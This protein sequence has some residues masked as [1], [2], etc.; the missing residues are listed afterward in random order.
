MLMNDFVSVVFILWIIF[1]NVSRNQSNS[2]L[3]LSFVHVFMQWMFV[4]GIKFVAEWGKN[5]SLFVHSLVKWIQLYCTSFLHHMN[6]CKLRLATSKQK[7]IYKSIN[8]WFIGTFLTRKWNNIFGSCHQSE[9]IKWWSI[10]FGR[11]LSY[12]YVV[13]VTSTN[14]DDGEKP[15]WTVN[16]AASTKLS[17]TKYID[18]RMYQLL[19]AH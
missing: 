12:I 15:F 6:G 8:T 3:E 14:V 11:L 16:I 9:R 10:S 5:V 7:I 18:L 13:V 17:M 1:S 4:I 2:T 19:T